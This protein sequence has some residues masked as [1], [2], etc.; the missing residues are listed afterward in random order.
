LPERILAINLR[1]TKKYFYVVKMGGV[2]ILMTYQFGYL[3]EVSS[4]LAWL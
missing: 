2:D 3:V 1:M 4:I